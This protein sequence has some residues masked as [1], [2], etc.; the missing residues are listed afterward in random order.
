MLEGK[1]Y[2]PTREA[3]S[4]TYRGSTRTVRALFVGVL[5]YDNV[6]NDAVQALTIFAHAKPMKQAVPPRQQNHHKK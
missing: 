5:S 3:A 1:Q 4:S 2:C 6:D